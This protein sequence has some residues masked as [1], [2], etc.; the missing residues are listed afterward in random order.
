MIDTREIESTLSLMLVEIRQ[1]CFQLERI[2]D[3]MVSEDTEDG[4]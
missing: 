4:K 2:G 3:I 1:I